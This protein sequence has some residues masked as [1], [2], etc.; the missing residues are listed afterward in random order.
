MSAS[1][2]PAYGI[3]RW[4][5]PLPEEHPAGLMLRLAQINLFRSVAVVERETNISMAEVKLGRG[6]ERLSRL[7]D[8]DE[9]GV[10]ANA[11]RHGAGTKVAIRGQQ[12]SLK[13]DLE[14]IRRRVCPDCVA[15]S[16]HARFWWDL[17]FVASC[18]R[19]GCRLEDRCGCA[20]RTP[21]G[22]RDGRIATCRACQDAGDPRPA[23]PLPAPAPILAVDA[24]L[25]G[26]LD[27]GP[28]R[29][30]PLIDALPLYEAVDVLE[31][32]GAFS[33]GGYAR[34]WPDAT[35]LRM[36]WND[37]LAEGYAVLSEGTLPEALDRVFDEGAAAGAAPA[38][39]MAYG[40]FYHWLNGKGGRAFSEELHRIVLDHAEARFVVDKRARAAVLPPTET[41]TLVEAT[42]RCGITQGVMRD[43][44][45][46]RGLVSRPKARGLP[47]RIPKADIRVIETVLRDSVDAE[48]AAILLGTGW[49]V[50]K[51]LTALRVLVPWVTG[52]RATKH[53]Y[54][55][56]RGEVLG[57]LDRLAAGLSAR[58][59]TDED[60]T[61]L[62]AA[63]HAYGVPLAVLC[64]EALEGRLF[65]Y[66]RLA[67][68][69]G[70]QGVIVQREEILE[71]R[72][73]LR[74][75]RSRSH[76][77]VVPCQRG[78]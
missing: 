24:Y 32:V 15:E 7:V 65:L 4:D 39:T 49:K 25:L 3:P 16:P 31:R 40:W 8:A 29:P 47:F 64:R 78:A 1:L 9:A 10:A 2:L 70:L 23:G 53:A 63:A 57:I 67:T 30:L 22:W 41:C 60:E 42:A 56:R 36:T 72:R 59:C 43:I 69:G 66:G 37:L 54:V 38:L 11:F 74:S 58:L 76:G 34:R 51:D 52:G 13:R 20:A 33:K 27:A 50:V 77:G 55:Y 19:H 75:V 71:V 26:R 45:E 5:Q 28:S 21:L 17:A 73:R 14:R 46:Q 44:L 12:I 62:T 61:T 6:L 48:G 18:P 35:F 68:G